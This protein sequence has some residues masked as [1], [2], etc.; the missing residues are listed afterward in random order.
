MLDRYMN[1]TEYDY[2]MELE[3]ALA[4]DTRAK[5]YYNYSKTTQISIEPDGNIL[6]TKTHTEGSPWQHFASYQSL[7]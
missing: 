7:L 2:N 4:M 5:A 6:D 1:L 3:H